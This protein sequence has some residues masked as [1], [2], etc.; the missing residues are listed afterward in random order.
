MKKIQQHSKKVS[1][2]NKT[3]TDSNLVSKIY[4]VNFV[5]DYI[6]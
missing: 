5:A 1:D 3:A 4:I 6:I 2:M